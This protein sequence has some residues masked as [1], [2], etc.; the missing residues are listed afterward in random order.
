MNTHQL[1]AVALNH[2]QRGRQIGIP[3]PVLAVF[4][5]GVGFLAVTVTKAR[6]DTQPDAMAG[7][8]LTS[9]SSI[10]TEPAFTGMRSS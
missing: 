1:Q 8:N 3:D 5:T 4:A 7:R 6:V 2:F 10:S 9:C